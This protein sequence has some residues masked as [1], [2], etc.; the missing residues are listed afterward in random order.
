MWDDFSPRRKPFYRRWWFAVPFWLVLLAALCGMAG[1]FYLKFEY[2]SQAAAFDYSRLE[3]MESASLVMDRSGNVMGRFFVQNRE[4]VPLSELPMDI[5]QAAIAAEDARFYSHRGVD[6]IGMARAA[7]KN[8]RAGRTR[9]G[10]STLT[11]QLARNTYPDQLPPKDRSYN[12]KLLEMFVAMEIEK[13]L[14]KS[15]IIELYLNRV[16]FGAG[17]YGVEAAARGYFHKSAR[18][19]TL[20]ECALL[21]GLLRNP[22]S[23]SPWTNRSACIDMRNVVLGRMLE[24][25]VIDKEKYDAAVAENPGV[26]NRRTVNTQSYAMDMIRQQT[27]SLLGSESAAS[28]GYRIY[29]TIDS[30]LQKRA[31]ETLREHLREVENRKD[32]EAQ[33]RADYERMLREQEKSSG[34]NSDAQPPSPEYLQGAAVVLDNATGAIL[35]LVGGRDYGQSQYNRATAARQPGTAFKPFVYAAAFEKGAFPGTP[36]Q[37]TEIDNR[38]VMIG[39]VTGILGEWGPE[40]ADNTFEGTISARE[41]LVKSKNAATVRIGTTTGIDNVI[42]L[43][44]SAGISTELA[45]YPRTFLGGSEATLMDMAL[46]YTI[47][48]NDGWRPVEPFVISRI[49]DRSGRNIYRS[50]TGRR[51]VIS[52]TTACEIN[53]CLSQVLEVG[54]GDKA[55]TQYGLRKFPVAGKTGTSYDF[56]DVWFLGYSSAI[57]CGVWAGF[58]KPRTI[59]RGA[60]SSDIALPVWVDIMNSSF[61]SYKPQEFAK[62]QAVVQ[63]EICRLSGMLATD[64]CVDETTDPATGETTRRST[65]TSEIATADQVTK[66]P[67]TMHNETAAGDHP[68]AQGQPTPGKWPRAIAAVNIAQI[69]PVMMK[70]PTILT[71]ED[72]YNSVSPMMTVRPAIRVDNGEAPQTDGTNATSTS[73]TAAPKQEPVTSSQVRRAEPVRTLD[74]PAQELPIK[75][76]A[77]PPLEF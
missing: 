67:C 23:L 77:P 13:R 35:A 69:P 18:N 38:Q 39:G 72:P 54:T 17:F 2:G 1:W 25:G 11:Q 32:Y 34:T 51:S 75:I 57:T 59:Y 28:E 14:P 4:A 40:R 56:K 22:N 61:A 3:E 10:A 27:A 68:A 52:D 70:A 33:T 8:V 53:S 49:E 19:L 45:R 60:F 7:L 6:V 29:T 43:A 58:D 36:V 5:I 55:F 62:P 74:K 26:K 71:D 63:R 30:A 9:E 76:D 44:K 65:K 20:S 16:Y 21:T 66:T 37:D 42:K 31:E 50:S 48:P 24:T 41:A 15:K 12:R 64:K 46:A 47:F 73:G